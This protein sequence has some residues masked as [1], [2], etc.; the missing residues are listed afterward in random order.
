[1]EVDADD[2]KMH[3][4]DHNDDNVDTDEPSPQQK[5]SC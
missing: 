4:P 3:T 2:G 5:V 1:M